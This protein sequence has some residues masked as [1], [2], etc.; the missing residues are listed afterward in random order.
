[1][2]QNVLFEGGSAGELL[3]A[4]DAQENGKSGPRSLL[5]GLLTRWIAILLF[6]CVLFDFSLVFSQMLLQ[7]QG[8]Y[9]ST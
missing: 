2:R 4:M 5:T 8:S 7:L 6:S 3:G 9:V 1:M